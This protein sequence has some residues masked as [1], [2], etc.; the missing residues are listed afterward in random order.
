LDD[1]AAAL[2]F[3]RAGVEI[4]ALLSSDGMSYAEDVG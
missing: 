4:A 2:L 1:E 3:R